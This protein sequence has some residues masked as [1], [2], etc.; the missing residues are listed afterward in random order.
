MT[1][2]DA[3]AAGA[4][5][6]EEKAAWLDGVNPVTKVVL[7]LLLSVPLFASIDVVSALAAIASTSRKGTTNPSAPSVTNSPC[8]SRS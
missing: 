5:T 4:I 6:R 7:A 8:Q 3:G 2:L 1:A